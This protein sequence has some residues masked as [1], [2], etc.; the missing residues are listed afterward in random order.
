MATTQAFQVSPPGPEDTKLQDFAEVIQ[1]NVSRLFDLS[2]E[3]VV[4]TTVPTISELSVGVPVTVLIGSTYYLY[5][6]VSTTQLARVSLTL[7]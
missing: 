7:V 6:K 4:R 2:H 1:R 3:H 5:V